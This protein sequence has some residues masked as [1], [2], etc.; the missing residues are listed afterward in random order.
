MNHNNSH[1]QILIWY[2]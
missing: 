2:W 1:N